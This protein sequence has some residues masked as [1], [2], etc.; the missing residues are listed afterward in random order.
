MTNKDSNYRFPLRRRLWWALGSVF[1][2]FVERGPSVAVWAAGLAN[3]VCWGVL[4]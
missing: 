2:S 3:I 1:D 4:L